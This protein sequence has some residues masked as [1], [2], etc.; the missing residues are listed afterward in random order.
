MNLTLHEFKVF[1][2]SGLI[3]SRCNFLPSL[4]IILFHKLSFFELQKICLCL[5]ALF[6][7][8]AKTI[9]NTVSFK[10]LTLFSNF[11]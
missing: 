3:E 5:F 11:L 9:P 6:K 10:T 7:Y 1:Y 8:S 2:Y 4:S